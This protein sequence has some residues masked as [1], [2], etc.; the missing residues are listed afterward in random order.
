M[1]ETQ[2]KTEKTAKK[3][4]A[5]KKTTKKAESAAPCV[6]GKLRNAYR[7]HILVKAPL[8]ADVPSVLLPLFRTRKPQRDVNVAVDVDPQSLL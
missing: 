1:S 3:T 6:I 2:E 7:W 4:P 8:G 5:R